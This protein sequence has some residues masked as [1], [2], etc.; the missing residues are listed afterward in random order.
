MSGIQP[1]QVLYS[2][3]ESHFFVMKTMD[4]VN[5][6]VSG[7]GYKAIRYIKN[8]HLYDTNFLIQM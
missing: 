1:P 5:S 8:K 4:K 7:Q 2:Q 3:T 6:S